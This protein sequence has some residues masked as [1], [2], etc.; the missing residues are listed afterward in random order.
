VSTEPHTITLATADH[1]PVTLP[2]PTWCR[3]HHDH[4]PDVY[5]C[6]LTHYG[7]ETV[8]TFEGA[9]V[10]R[11]MV[12]ESPYATRPE[13]RAVCGYVEARGYTGALNAVQLYGLAAA[14]DGHADRLRDL[15]D[16]VDTIT[17]GGTE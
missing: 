2:E 5:R 11:V 1:G 4:R 8:L 6:D 13:D 12:S 16:Q 7:T 14:L 3:G 15:A 17:A 10:F 9:E